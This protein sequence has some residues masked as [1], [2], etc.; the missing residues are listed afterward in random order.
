MHL[1]D[2]MVLASERVFSG[3]CDISFRS[4]ISP[5]KLS[6]FKVFG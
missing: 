4:Y 6:T 2:G 3:L 5:L 1:V